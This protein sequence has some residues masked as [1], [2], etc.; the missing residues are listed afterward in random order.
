MET[1]ATYQFTVED[2]EAALWTQECNSAYAVDSYGLSSVED[3]AC[4]LQRELSYD[5]SLTKEEAK[6]A[7]QLYR[8][9]KAILHDTKIIASWRFTTGTSSLAIADMLKDE[10]Q[11]SP[12]IRVNA[13][14]IATS[15][16][17][18]YVCLARRKTIRRQAA[19]N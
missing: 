12:I 14:H 10:E 2:V 4:A 18:R 17:H 9:G 8:Q 19:T 16:A 3:M 5:N 15:E 7:R 11:L 13:G 1:E 6:Q